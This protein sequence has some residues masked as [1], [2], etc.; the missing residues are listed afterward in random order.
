ME[1]WWLIC[2]IHSEYSFHNLVSVNIYF[3]MFKYTYHDF[4]YKSMV[5]SNISLKTLLYE[6][7][8]LQKYMVVKV[9]SNHSTN[10]CYL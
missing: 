7:G 5:L 3:C 6:I 10:T 9:K 1:M 2:K 8:K 4:G